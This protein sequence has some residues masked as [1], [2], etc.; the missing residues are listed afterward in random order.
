MK[1]SMLY[2]KQCSVNGLL[3]AMLNQ[4][5]T[6]QLSS[7]AVASWRAFHCDTIRTAT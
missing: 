3:H 4:H 7:T 6:D 5:V 1:K 2:V